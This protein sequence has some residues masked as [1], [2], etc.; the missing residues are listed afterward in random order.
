MTDLLAVL[1]Q[2]DTDAASPWRGG[3]DAVRSGLRR[4]SGCKDRAGRPESNARLPVFLALLRFYVLDAAGRM[5]LLDRLG[6]FARAVGD[7]VSGYGERCSA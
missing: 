2:E 7:W 6:G 5:P 1:I 3:G 4:T